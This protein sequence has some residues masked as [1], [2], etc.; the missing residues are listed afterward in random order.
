[1]HKAEDKGALPLLLCAKA[2]AKR[3]A[4]GQAVDL[5]APGRRLRQAE[6]VEQV[7]SGRGLH[8]QPD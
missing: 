6:A 7:V 2:K 8:V 4:E 5:E 1:M 3:T